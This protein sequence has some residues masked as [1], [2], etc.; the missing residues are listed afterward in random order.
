VAGAAP[1]AILS[2]LGL[3]FVNRPERLGEGTKS[4]LYFSD[5]RGMVAETARASP[6]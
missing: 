2:G 1:V 6:Y 4:L 3:D 5:N